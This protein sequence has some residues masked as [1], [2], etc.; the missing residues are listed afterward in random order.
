LPSFAHKAWLINHFSVILTFIAM[1][2]VGIY[3]VVT[4]SLKKQKVAHINKTKI[5]KGK[6]SRKFAMLLLVALE[7]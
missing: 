1:A 4:L 7:S 3:F 5:L 2:F 6:V